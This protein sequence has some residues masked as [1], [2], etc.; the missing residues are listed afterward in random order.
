MLEL[1]EALSGVISGT[2]ETIKTNGF[3]IVKPE[4]MTD[5]I[6]AVRDGEHTCIDFKGEKGKIRIEFF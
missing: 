5:D 6:P 1:N 4:N 2:A 3:E